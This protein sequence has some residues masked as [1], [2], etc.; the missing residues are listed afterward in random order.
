MFVL[1]TFFQLNRRGI[2]FEHVADRSCFKA[3]LKRGKTVALALEANGRI[4]NELM[5]SWVVS[6]TSDAGEDVF[7]RHRFTE[8]RNT[9][10]SLLSDLRYIGVIYEI[11][12][13]WL[14][15]DLIADRLPISGN[16]LSNPY[17]RAP[18]NRQ[19]LALI[20]FRERRYA[21]ILVF[22]PLHRS[23]AHVIWEYFTP[24]LFLHIKT[25]LDLG[26]FHFCLIEGSNIVKL[27]GD[28]VF[29]C[30]IAS[31]AK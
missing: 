18:N 24:R 23:V 19:N 6:T 13:L 1:A 12:S 16:L 17:I 28:R 25:T 4:I 9:F 2:C 5:S 30:I 7:T 27:G 3:F 31:E 29:A 10:D 26:F 14:M 21:F 20:I 8:V 15:E 11:N 22:T